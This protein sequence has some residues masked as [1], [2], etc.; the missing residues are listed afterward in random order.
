MSE[1]ACATL[2]GYIGHCYGVHSQTAKYYGL[3]EGFGGPQSMHVDPFA[4]EH[5]FTGYTSV[6][7]P[8]LE[9]AE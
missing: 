6:E 1:H 7:R 9:A 3:T 5:G 2:A 8:S 4:K